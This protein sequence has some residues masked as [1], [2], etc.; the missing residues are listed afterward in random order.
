MEIAVRGKWIFPVCICSSQCSQE[1]KPPGQCRVEHNSLNTNWEVR[2]GIQIRSILALQSFLWF[3]DTQASCGVALH[4][5][6]EAQK[7][8]GDKALHSRLSMAHTDIS[9]HWAAQQGGPPES[10]D[11]FGFVPKQPLNNDFCRPWL[12][13]W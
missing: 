5:S 13:N 8:F 2:R 3:G 4:L 7:K 12:R 6:F 11:S 9:S 1:L 10:H